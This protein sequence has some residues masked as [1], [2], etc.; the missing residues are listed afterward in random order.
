MSASQSAIRPYRFEAVESGVPG[1][2][3]S[4]IFIDGE[5]NM[6]S[7]VDGEIAWGGRCLFR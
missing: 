4:S 2:N 3:G 5:L 7:W 1:F 6:I